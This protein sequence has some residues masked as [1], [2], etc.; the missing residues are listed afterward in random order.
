MTRIS[1]AILALG[2]G[3]YLAL[4]PGEA[5]AS[6]VSCGD[7][8]TA[9]T[10]LDSDLLDCPE[11]GVI[12]GADNI[13]LDLNGHLIDGDGSC[14]TN[15]FC[16]GVQNDGH[17]GVTVSDGSV[18]QFYYGVVVRASDNRV[19]GISASE[20]LEYGIS[21]EGDFEHMSHILIRDSSATDNGFTGI[22]VYNSHDVQIVHNSVEHNKWGLEVIVGS[23]NVITRNLVSRN[24]QYG[25][26][27]G[28]RHTQVRRNRF[29]RNHTGIDVWHSRESLIARNHVSLGRKGINLR[30]GRGM[31]VAR[32]LI[33]R[34]GRHGLRLAAQSGR[35]GVDN[36]VRRNLVRKSGGDGFLVNPNHHGV[37]SHNTAR[38][39]RDDGFHIRSLVTKLTGNR[40][41]RNGDLGIEAVAGVTDGGGNRASGNGNARQCVNVTCH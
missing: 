33:V 27:L 35:K 15:E 7:T 22:S 10:T 36:I 26:I 11:Y 14:S 13:T 24:S 30:N 12:I 9:D 40:A 34:P 28:D 4:S 5:S 21:V 29:V 1:L 19:V 31:R 3:G 23:D 6:H 37:L 38:R 41:V 39:A 2:V 8:I 16:S 18:R 17:D 32:N 20:N 25:I